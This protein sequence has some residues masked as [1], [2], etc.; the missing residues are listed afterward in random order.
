[1]RSVGRSHGIKR[2]LQGRWSYVLIAALCGVGILTTASG[3][4]SAGTRPSTAKVAATAGANIKACFMVSNLGVDD[5]GFNEEGWNALRQAHAT[6]GM[7][8]EYL[9]E[10]GSVTWTTIG[11]EFISEGCNLIVGEG[12]DTATEIQT[13]A[14]AYPNLKFALIDDTLPKTMKNVAELYYHTDQGAFLGGYVAAAMAKSKIVGMFGNE[15]I[16]PVLLYLNGFYAGVK[17][18]DKLNNAKVKTIGYNPVTHSGEFMGSF[19]STTINTQITNSELAQGADIIYGV[20]LPNS[21]AEAVLHYGHKTASIGVDSDGCFSYPA[22]CPA[23]LTSV[24]KNITPSLLDVI[25]SDVKGHFDSGIYN[26][27]LRNNGVGIATYH[28]WGTK[29]PSAVKKEVLKLTK[30]VIAGTINYDPYKA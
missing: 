2:G 17:Y 25:T 11:S 7:K 20:G 24:E 10:S 3:V 18:Y 30:E 5:H 12:F 26:G 13:L 23:F 22:L 15:P 27:T 4:A 19:T 21:V 29:V 28:T 16:P 8:I 14:Q 9:A 1:L 6:Y